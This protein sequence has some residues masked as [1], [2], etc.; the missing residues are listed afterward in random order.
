MVGQQPPLPTVHLRRGAAERIHAGHPWVYEGNIDRLPS[1]L[2]DG[3]EVQVRDARRRFLGTGLYNSRSRI[4]VRLLSRLR[5]TIDRDFFTRRLRTARI[6]RERTMPGVSCHRLVHAE[7][8]LLSGLV[9]DRY[10]DVLCLQITSLGIEER[11]PLIKEVLLDLQPNARVVQRRDLAIRKAEGL[12][13]DPPSD[14]EEEILVP[15]GTLRFHVDPEGGHK[16]GLYLDQQE[17]YRRVTR[18]LEQWDA[19]RILDAFTYQGA[20][21]L[22]AASLPG[23]RV[24]AID[25]SREA[26]DRAERNAR[27]N[28]LDTGCSFLTAN[29]FDWFKAAPKDAPFDAIILDPPSFTRTRA[30]VDD[31]LRGYK[32]I[33]LRALRLLV[34]GGLLVSFCCS[35]HVDGSTFERTILEAALDNRQHLR[36]VARF[37]QSSDH[38]VLPAVPETSYLKGF[39][40]ELL[41]P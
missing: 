38:P 25:Q 41:C 40:H 17:N 6:L 39:A 11:L 8:D 13:T 37:G 7:G 1:D 23:R 9:I 10:Q 24:V 14:G 20:F 32:E 12:P 16:T 33:H 15:F 36:E 35:H 34:P 19:R 5:E 4:R 31:A 3:R 22:H 28:G 2:R 30:S 26:L 29:V 18:L 27:T 21:A